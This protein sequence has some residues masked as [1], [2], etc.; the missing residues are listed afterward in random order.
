MARRRGAR[1]LLAPVRVEADLALSLLGPSRP[2]GAPCRISA[3]RE[4]Y[5]PR[6]WLV[7]PDPTSH[8]NSHGSRQ[9]SEVQ[10]GWIAS[11]R[12]AHRAGRQVNR[13]CNK[14]PWRQRPLKLR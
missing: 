1:A 3:P 9:P 13:Q 6:Q 2:C 5:G 11:C 14:V 8:Q 7:A 10:A 4:Q 12:A